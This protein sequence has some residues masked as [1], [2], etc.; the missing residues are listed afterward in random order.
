MNSDEFGQAGPVR[1]R[2]PKSRDIWAFLDRR[3]NSDSFAAH[4][5][6]EGWLGLLAID[7]AHRDLAER[8]RRPAVVDL[9]NDA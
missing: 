4:F 9:M 6:R 2:P 5:V 7:C 1:I 3:G 8:P